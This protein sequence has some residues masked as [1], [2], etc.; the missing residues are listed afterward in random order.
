MKYISN[1]M[2]YFYVFLVII[3]IKKY[4]VVFIAF[5]ALTWTVFHSDVDSI[6]LHLDSI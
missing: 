5:Y 2:D 1:P 4:L 3:N 6:M